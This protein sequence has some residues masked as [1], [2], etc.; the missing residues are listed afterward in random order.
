MLWINSSKIFQSD[1]LVLCY[2]AILGFGTS[3]FTGNTLAT[4]VFCA[5]FGVLLMV[6]LVVIS[7]I[8]VNFGVFHWPRRVQ[9]IIS[10][11]LV[12]VLAACVV[13]Q[14]V[15]HKWFNAF[16]TTSW[17]LAPLFCLIWRQVDR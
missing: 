5:L 2:G 12:A 17:I 11:L 9:C 13:I 15:E 7:R 4:A 3:W 6:S 10:I 14:L 8:P 1:W 16:M